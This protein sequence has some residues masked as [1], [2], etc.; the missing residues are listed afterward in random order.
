MKRLILMLFVLLGSGILAAA[1]DQLPTPIVEP[2]VTPVAPI[3]PIATDALRVLVDARTDLELLVQREL[4]TERPLG[5]SGSLEIN[6][7]HLVVL[8]RL[9]LELLAA[10]LIS[11]DTRPF[12]W[13]GAQAGAPFITATDIRHDLE[14]LANARLGI[15]VRPT[16]WTGGS[17]MTGCARET[18]VLAYTL[19][20][21]ASFVPEVDGSMAQFCTISASQLEAYAGQNPDALIVRSAPAQA[22]AGSVSGSGQ[23]TPQ[24]N[25]AYG[26]LDRYATQR[27][28]IIPATES[29]VPLA[30][31]F[32]QFSRMTLIQGTGFQVFVDWKT[33]SMTENDFRN[34]PNVN[35]FDAAPNCTAAWCTFALIA[36]VEL[37]NR[38]RR[39]TGGLKE[40]SGG[41][42]MRV[43][44]DA[45]TSEGALVRMEVCQRRTSAKNPGCATANSVVLSNGAALPAV[46]TVGN[47]PQYLMPYG[48]SNMRITSNCCYTNEV[49]IST[50]R[51]RR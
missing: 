2:T 43:F 11:V 1:Q 18:Q 27:I 31:S 26:F 46:N 28:G 13:F 40:V 47:M 15:G 17:A 14:L 22:V 48:F 7:P 45:D 5:W 37:Q 8:I 9:D 25:A 23:F 41:T 50:S 34:L 10:R 36:P 4:G 30:R 21:N 35:D 20:T 39:G 3:S 29:F 6:D 38:G 51:E 44:Y 24:G 32:T 33:T 12:G 42:H 19:L 49:Y 16:G